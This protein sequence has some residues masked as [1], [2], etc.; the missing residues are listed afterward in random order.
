MTGGQQTSLALPDLR[1][2]PLDAGAAPSIRDREGAA[3]TQLAFP[4][5]VDTAPFSPEARWIDL[6]LVSLDLETT[7]PDPA[8][9]RVLEV[10]AI[11]FARGQPL[12]RWSSLVNPGCEIPAEASAI[13]GITAETL[14]GVGGLD[15]PSAELED[16]ETGEV[17]S[18]GH[19]VAARLAGRVVVG[20]NVLRYDLPVLDRELAAA[21]CARP[22]ALVIDVLVWIRKLDR[23]V[24][25][26]GR[27]RLET[28]AKRHGVKMPPTHRA[29]ADAEVTIRLLAAIRDR[30][31]E[32]LG[33][34]VREQAR[35]VVE[36]EEDRARWLAR[37]EASA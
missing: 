33:E 17:L 11:R 37:Q 36:Q 25:G 34:L 23:F 29:L 15:S 7:G 13:H 16:P 22:S 31:P 24:A 20:Y 3:M 30:L 12:D 6:P 5:V 4:G 9:A 35:L 2:A 10:A 32:T 21:R 26:K 19:E 8:T 18:V 27:H 14:R 28:T 1:V